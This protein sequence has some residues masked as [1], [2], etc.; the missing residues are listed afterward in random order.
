MEGYNEDFRFED[1]VLHVRLSGTFPNELLHKGQNLFQPLVDACATH[2]CRKAL[3]D[4]RDLQVDF[5]TTALFQA[6]KD[7]AFLFREGFRI[8]LVARKDLIDPFFED[9]VSNRGGNVGV[10]TDMDTA[11]DRLQRQ[12]E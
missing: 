2:N 1:G 7:A 9:V 3:I 8:A 10:F 4:A 6:G 11:L 5:D 12:A